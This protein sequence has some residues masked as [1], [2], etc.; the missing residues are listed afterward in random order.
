[1]PKE[2]TI[3]LRHIRSVVGEK[4]D[5]PNSGYN[6]TLSNMLKSQIIR[7]FGNPNLIHN[8]GAYELDKTITLN[9]GE[10]NVIS[11][12]SDGKYLYAGSQTSPGMIVRVDINTFTRESAL[13]LD[14]GE[15]VINYLIMQ[16]D[17]IYAGLGTSPGKIVKIN[18]KSFTRDS[19]LTLD[20]GENTIYQQAI[21]GIYLY[22]GL[23]TS[24]AKITRINLNTFTKTSTLTFAVNEDKITSLYMDRGFLYAGFQTN[25]AIIKQVDTKTFTESNSLTM[26]AGESNIFHLTSDGI[27]IY[28]I[29][30]ESPAKIFK[31]SY[32]PETNTLSRIKSLTLPVGDNQAR[33]LIFNGMHLIAGL[34][35]SPAKHV[36]IDQSTFEPVYTYTFPIGSD[37]LHN[38]YT[39]GIYIYSPHYQSPSK[40]SRTYILPLNDIFQKAITLLLEQTH[41]G[42]YYTYPP[43]AAGVT[44]TSAAGAYTKGN[45]IEII[46]VNTI[47]TQFFITGVTLSN[48]TV[49]TDYELDIATGLAAA[50]VIVATVSHI[51]DNTNLAHEC[52]FPIPIKISS[53]TRISARS[54]DG[55]GSLTSIVKIRYKI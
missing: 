49:N 47:S 13:T 20:A 43:N 37:L 11:I 9:S 16:G 54:S 36:Y 29:T 50:E 41:T 4:T 15:N 24:P 5:L 35:T 3:E 51:T 2:E 31:I 25:P 28:A 18:R 27:Y 53:N 55:T 7:N 8:T 33:G 46:P 30:S 23:H 21:D 42:R 38:L 39:D 40:I 1:M 22:A 34:Y 52:L 44:I 12:L 45:Y 17:Y 10:N 48:L 32:D 26:E 14:V 19:V 6:T